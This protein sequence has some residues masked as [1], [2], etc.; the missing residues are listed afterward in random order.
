MIT[1]EL[2]LNN[3]IMTTE[4]YIAISG[5]SDSEITHDLEYCHKLAMD[6]ENQ[7]SRFFENSELS[8]FNSKDGNIK[9]SRDLYKMLELSKSYYHKTNGLFDPA[10]L[11]SLLNEGYTASKNVGFYK[12]LDESN[13]TQKYKIIDLDLCEYPIIKK[14]KN[15]IIDLGGIG[16]GYLINKIVEHLDMKYTNYCINI[17][18]DMYLSGCDIE[19]GYDYWAI[20]IHNPTNNKLEMPT[21]ILKNISVATSGVNNRN[22]T[23]NNKLKNHVINTRNYKSVK[24]DLLTVTVIT[25]SVIDADVFAKTLL[26]LGSVDGLRFANK[27]KLSAIFVTKKG[28][29]LFSNESNKY[30]WSE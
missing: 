15:L 26:I 20:P 19:Q 23:A 12:K 24:N 11:P 14:P 25:K 18:G 10:I 21:L 27:N 28:K 2:Q 8:I 5:N 16:K 3:E 9:V 30:V 4:F 22:W 29:I 6:F 13:Y 1:R 17:G 7:Y